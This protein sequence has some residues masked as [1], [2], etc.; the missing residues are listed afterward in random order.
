MLIVTSPAGRAGI[1]DP[2]VRRLVQTRF[3]QI[4]DGEPYD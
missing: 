3:H 4:T 1:E 2:D